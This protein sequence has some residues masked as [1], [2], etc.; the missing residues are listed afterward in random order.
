MGEQQEIIILFTKYPLPGHSKT[1]LIPKLGDKGAA[2]LQR[3]M[4]EEAVAKLRRLQNSRPVNVIIHFAGGNHTLMQQWLGNSFHFHLQVGDD[5]GD[6][7]AKSISNHFGQFSRIVLIGSDCPGINKAILCQALDALNENDLVIG[8]T[9]DG[10]YY[11]VGV[12]AT[13]L[14]EQLDS[15]FRDMRWST[16]SVLNDTMQKIARLNLSCHT[17]PKLHD[18]DTPDDLRHIGHYSDPQ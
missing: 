11:L 3:R 13:V 16:D 14:P 10:G 1:R 4:G 6:R 8:P 7:M 17:L 18:I 12:R 5:I 2:G 15:L 9:F